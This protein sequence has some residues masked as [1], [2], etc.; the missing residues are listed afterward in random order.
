MNASVF[1][2]SVVSFNNETELRVFIWSRW[3]Q[4]NCWQRFQVK[5][6]AKQHWRDAH[7]RI[8][9]LYSRDMPERDVLVINEYIKQ[10]N[11]L[12]VFNLM[13]KTP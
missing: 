6:W 10:V 2:Q 12:N 1:F 4:L 9:D 8:A 13:V 11:N 5:R 3:T 7:A